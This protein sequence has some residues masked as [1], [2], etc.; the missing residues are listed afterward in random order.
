MRRPHL[1]PIALLLFATAACG[2]RSGGSGQDIGSIAGTVRIG[3]M[4]PVVQ[5]GSPCPDQPWAGTIRVMTTTG[6][7]VTE[8]RSGK[9]GTFSVDVPT[10]TYDVVAKPEGMGPPTGDPRRVSVRAGATTKVALTLD[11]GIR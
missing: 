11:S 3:P 8:T 10:G 7:T 2:S 9:D 6:T 1:L 4:C 5:A